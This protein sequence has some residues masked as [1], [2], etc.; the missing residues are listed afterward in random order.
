MQSKKWLLSLTFELLN[1]KNSLQLLENINLL[2]L[3][4]AMPLRPFRSYHKVIFHQKVIIRA[5]IWILS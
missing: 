5:Q 2:A 1:N 3:I 4:T